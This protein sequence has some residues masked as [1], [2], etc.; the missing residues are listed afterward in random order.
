[1]FVEK[2][3]FIAKK[4]Y[5]FHLNRS[6]MFR[7]QCNIFAIFVEILVMQLTIGKKVP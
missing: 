2:T 1:M 5:Q 4:D 3:R 7:L 6:V